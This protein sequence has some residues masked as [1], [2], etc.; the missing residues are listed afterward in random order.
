MTVLRPIDEPQ[1]GPTE[2]TPPLIA[3]AQA[4]AAICATRMLLLIALL[5]GAPLWLYA[6]YEPAAL[7]IIA[8]T[9]YALV[10]VLPLVWL[11]HR[12]G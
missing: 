12:R 5:A 9:A 3:M 8:A 4:V 6:V 10:V 7:R 1:P 11:Y 2:V